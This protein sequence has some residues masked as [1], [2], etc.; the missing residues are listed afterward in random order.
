MT[1]KIDP[2]DPKTIA[3]A[4]KIQRRIE[5]VEGEITKIEEEILKVIDTGMK[6]IEDVFRTGLGWR[7]LSVETT[8]YYQKMEADLNRYKLEVLQYRNREAFRKGNEPDETEVHELVKE[9]KL[10]YI[11]TCEEC[12]SLETTNS[13]KLGLYLNYGVFLYDVCDLIEDSRF[14][15]KK[16]F[17]EAL[18]DLE[19]LNN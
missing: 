17:D 10:I 3:K 6:C 16:C 1:K 15:L 13:L 12:E 14:V 9:T 4:E 5:L 7:N 8:V 2:Y 18:K 19:R 11:E